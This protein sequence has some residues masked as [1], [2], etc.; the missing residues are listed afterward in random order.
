MVSITDVDT[1]NC[2]SREEEQRWREIRNMESWEYSESCSNCNKRQHQIVKA[3]QHIEVEVWCWTISCYAC[4]KTTPVI[5]T[6]GES[7]R[8][9]RESI[10]PNTFENLPCAIE[11]EYPLFKKGFKKTK[12]VEEHGNTC[13]HC[14]AYQGDW[15]VWHEYLEIA[16][17]PESVSE[18]KII[19]VALTEYEQ[20]YYANPKQL[21][22]MHHPR[23][24]AYR[25][26]CPDCYDLYKKKK[27]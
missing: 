8:F 6:N 3:P 1:W 14:G 22:R 24:G 23:K 19:L 4:K 16:Y 15:F 7:S 20:L 25:D 26:L 12:N 17:E 9:I 10:R 18:S 27:I 2:L 13:V 21:F 5:W 11:Q